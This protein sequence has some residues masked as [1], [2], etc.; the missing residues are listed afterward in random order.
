M[1]ANLVGAR[2]LLQ[3]L[4]A[5]AAQLLVATQPRSRIAGVGGDEAGR[6]RRAIL[7]RLRRALPHERIHRMAGVAEQG[8]VADRPALQRLAVEQRPYETRIGRGGDPANLWMPA[9][10]RDERALD[11]GAIGPV[12][13]VPR[14]V[15]GPSDEIQQPAARDEVVHEVPAG[16]DPR[17][18]AELQVELGETLGR[19]QSAIRDAAGEARRFLAEQPGA[20]RRV[21]AVGADQ[22]VGRDALA[23]LEPGRDAVA[24]VVQP[25][26]AVTEV[27]AFGHETRGDDREQV[28][29]MNGQMGRAVELLAARIERRALQRAAVL[30]A[31]LVSAA[32]PH[33]LAVER[34]A[35]TQAI[36]DARRVRPHVDPAADFGQFGRLLVDVDVEAGPGAAPPRR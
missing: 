12:L 21:D 17:L 16:A 29:A 9:V 5:G 26:Q 24:L 15:L 4:D 33:R 34:G 36:Q 11:R 2:H 22:D 1:E 10:E 35:E 31:P 14:V 19:D 13:A 3:A 32:G 27:N 23:V 6:Q 25:D 28:G 20:P 30:P 8:D 18:R 7:D